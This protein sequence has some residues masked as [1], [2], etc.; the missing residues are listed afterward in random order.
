[1]NK[2]HLLLAGLVIF[3]FCE[4]IFVVSVGSVSIPLGKVYSTLW[5]GIASKHPI[6]GIGNGPYYDI[7]WLLRLPRVILAVC[8]GSCLAVCGVVMQAIV[9]NP[10]ADPF[11]L[12]VSSG[13]ALGATLA[14]FLGV[15]TAM[16]A[17]YIGICAFMGALC[18]SYLVLIIANIGNSS[19][20][21]KLLLVGMALNA[22]CSSITSFITY[23]ANDKDGMQS[24]L[25]WLMG[26]FAGAS[27]SQLMPI[28]IVTVGGIVF[29]CSQSRILNMMLLGDQTAITLGT[30][31]KVYRQNYLLLISVMVGFVV[32]L[33]GMVGFV[34]LIVPHIVR[35]LVGANHKFLVPI[36]VV[37]GGIILLT[38]DVLCRSM[39][40]RLEIPVGILVSFIGAPIFA[41]LIANKLGR[42][43]RG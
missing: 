12:G 26:S 19:N 11:I 10:L 23:F 34:G 17:N 25:F 8:A 37:M 43:E 24:V 28:G 29:F 15:G 5:Q 18:I 2:K 21:V 39:I 7:I 41:F 36:S 20:P 13:A 42:S 40:P 14:I 38:A 32:A 1:M 4:M 16:G 9:K 30:N 31:L 27:W 35:M 33:S 6:E 22:A 3:L